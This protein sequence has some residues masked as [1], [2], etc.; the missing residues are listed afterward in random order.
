MKEKQL[1]ECAICSNCREKIL[2]AGIPLF[3]RV[4]IE[5]FGIRMDRVQRHTG[6]EMMLS[7]SLASIMGT[8]EELAEPVM[9]KKEITICEKCSTEPICVARLAELK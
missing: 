2:S 1:R 8:D 6:L 9:E 7:P 3:Y 4:S 5:R